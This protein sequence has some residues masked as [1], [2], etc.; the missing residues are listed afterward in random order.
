MKFDKTPKFSNW[1]PWDQR[2][3]LA[4]LQFPGIYALAVA[5]SMSVRLAGKPFEWREDI[6]YF[7]M[8]NSRAGLKGRLN[9]FNNVLTGKTGHGGAERFMNDWAA[10]DLAPRLYVAVWAFVCEVASNAPKDLI[11]MGCVA[12]A[13][14]ECFARYA[15]L[16]GTLPKYNNK[17]DSPKRPK[18]ERS[19]QSKS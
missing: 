3:E 7:G 17:A 13:E 14:F 12:K 8:T 6:K 2:G 1:V 16:Y 11:I 15:E 18:A 10:A 4:C 5:G 9:Q 19:P